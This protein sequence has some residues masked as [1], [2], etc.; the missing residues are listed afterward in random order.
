MALKGAFPFILGLAAGVIFNDMIR[1]GWDWLR[2]QV[3][4]VPEIPSF[5][6][7]A[8]AAPEPEPVPE[9]PAAGTAAYAYKADFEKEY[10]SYGETHNNG[11][12][13]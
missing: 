12:P 13:W 5:G 10:E 2:G 3:P 11:I 4:Q 7:G 1:Q 9:A 6:G 8:P